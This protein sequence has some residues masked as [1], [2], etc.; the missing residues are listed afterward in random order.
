MK[1]KKILSILAVTSFLV[2]L[3]STVNA[4]AVEENNSPVIG[5]YTKPEAI[6]AK[7]NKIAGL[8][9]ASN[10][11]AYYKLNNSNDYTQ[12]DSELIRIIDNNVRVDVVGL[13][14]GTYD[15]KLV[16]NDKVIE[17]TDIVV[18]ADD[19]SGYAHFNRTEGVGAYKNDGTLKDNAVVV[20]VNDSNKN[21]VTA[22]INSKTYTGLADIIKNAKSDFIPVDIR[23][24]GTIATK[25]WNEIDYKN[26]KNVGESTYE[27]IANKYYDLTI[28]NSKKEDIRTLSQSGTITEESIINN[29]FNSYEN[30]YTKLDGLTN[31]ITYSAD[32]EV[33]VNN[34]KYT[35]NNNFDS[36]FNMLDVDGAKNVTVEGIGDDANIFQW[37]FTWKRSNSIEI[38]NLIFTDFPEDACAFQGDKIEV[39]KTTNSYNISGIDYERAWIHNC[40]FNRGKNNWDVTY[41]Q[42]KHEGDG[43]TDI[44]FY[45]NV[46]YS[47][48]HYN[49]NHKT[50]LVGGS[51]SNISANITF[52]H[53]WYESCQSRMPYARQANMHMYNNFYDSS[54][55]KTMQLYAGAYAFVENCYFKNDNKVY[56]LDSKGYK[57]SAIKAFNNIF[58]GSK[59]KPSEV[60][61]RTDSVSN[62]NILIS[63]NET[64][65]SFQNFDTNS[66][67]F[68]YDDTNHCSNVT[69]M[70]NASELPTLLLQI[71]GAGK[72]SET[73]SN[74]KTESSELKEID[75]GYQ[76]GTYKVEGTTYNAVRF[77]GKFKYG[78]NISAS[79]ISSIKMKFE[80]YDTNNELRNTINEE[81]TDIY[82]VI[83]SGDVIVAERINGVKYYYFVINDITSTH[84][85]YKIVASSTITLD[86]NVVLCAQEV[87][88]ISLS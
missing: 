52:H 5:V 2:S 45:K 63:G 21:S 84:N 53:N 67:L 34:V 43:S 71:S 58:D 22:T 23:I 9:D 70:N 30:N 74:I 31:K 78:E 68:Y 66:N 29:D 7:F 36:Y 20:Y 60:E 10:Y 88:Q 6:A 64:T 37:G 38:K 4:Y 57:D 13:K 42:D 12:I 61:N 77:V 56:E 39:T 82:S 79:D 24:I 32:K 14:A 76:K 48:N 87:Y 8:N 80:I 35:I 73:F 40:T 26:N 75:L 41:E 17:M 3:F 18:K 44:K 16:A 85:G 62:G 51:E 59:T 54:T 55:G 86:N 28:L 49:N 15:L 72:Y 11:S 83:K 19:R 33:T 27:L 69:L 65:Y 1:I 81:I 50:G 25:T 46:T 47:Y